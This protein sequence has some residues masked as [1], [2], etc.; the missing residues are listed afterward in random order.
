MPPNPWSGLKILVYLRD[1]QHDALPVRPVRLHQ[2]LD[3]LL[4]TEQRGSQFQ[5][6]SLCMTSALFKRKGNYDMSKFIIHH[7]FIRTTTNI[8]F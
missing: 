5:C 4:V 8:F 3:V 6:L 7:K 1:V 2:L